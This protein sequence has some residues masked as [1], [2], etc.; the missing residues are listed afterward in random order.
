MSTVRLIAY[1]LYK[2]VKPHPTSAD[3]V[4]IVVGASE[5]RINDDG[6]LELC[7]ASGAMQ[8]PDLAAHMPADGLLMLYGLRD[9]AIELQRMRTE[10]RRVGA[11]FAYA[12]VEIEIGDIEVGLVDRK[13]LH[14]AKDMRFLNVRRM[15]SSLQLEILEQF[16]KYAKEDGTDFNEELSR[17]S[18][19]ATRPDLWDEVFEKDPDLKRLDVLVIPI[20]DNPAA[21]GAMRNVAYVR[22]GARIKSIVQ[23]SDHV[24]LVLPGWMCKP[25]LKSAPEPAT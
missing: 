18:Q 8:S 24:S 15:K 14:E 9:T 25:L 4:N 5:A 20:A 6:K 2:S 23:G 10:A 3:E 22:P 17:V 12:D 21:P 19:I 1:A 11:E 13:L 7:M 16:S